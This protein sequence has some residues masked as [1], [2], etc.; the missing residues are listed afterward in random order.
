[1]TL[2][3]PCRIIAPSD[4]IASYQAAIEENP[5][6]ERPAKPGSRRKRS[7]GSWSKFWGSGRTLRITFMEKLS[8]ALKHRIEQIIR[9]WEPS[10]SLTFMFDEKGVGDIRIS[11]GGDHNESQ[12]GTDAKLV[13]EHEPTLRV[14]V[15]PE[16]PY[17]ELTVLHEFGHAL[18]MQHE[19]QHPL[20]NIPWDKPKVYEYYKLHF[21]WS[22][23]EIDF[24][25]FSTL[26]RD[27]LLQ[28]AYDRDS[29]MHYD[30]SNELT[31]GDFE[32]GINTK[33]SK[34]DRRGMR[35]AYPK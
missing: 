13:P 30:I 3:A 9:Q 4:P 26:D 32:I 28:G 23:E 24:N 5:N 25:L 8:P 14:S 1:M 17:F 15:L 35:K 11:L 29:I 33:I 34:L 12:M 7:I 2:I 22:K 31:I 20:A 27:D 16:D 6:N 10:T 18:G 19:H 21:Q